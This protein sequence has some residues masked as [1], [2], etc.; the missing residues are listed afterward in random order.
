MVPEGI[1]RASC[2]AAAPGFRRPSCRRLPPR[3][4]EVVRGPL[5]RAPVAR[6]PAQAPP[7]PARRPGSSPA[8]AAC[9]ASASAR[10]RP[11]GQTPAR[12]RRPRPPRRRRRRRR[13]RPRRPSTARARRAFRAGASSQRPSPRRPFR[14]RP[15]RT[16]PPPEARSPRPRRSCRPRRPRA[17]P[18]CGSGAGARASW[19]APPRPCPHRVAASS[20]GAGLG[21][22]GRRPARPA[23]PGALLQLEPLA[24]LALHLRQL[25]GVLRLRLELDRGRLGVE[26]RR[27]GAG[28]AGAVDPDAVVLADVADRPTDHDPVAPVQAGDPVGGVVHVRLGDLDAKL[29]AVGHGQAVAV[30]VGARSLA[31]HVDLGERHPLDRLHR[32]ALAGLALKLDQLRPAGAGELRRDPCVHA[33]EEGVGARRTGQLPEPPLGLDR[34]RLLGEDAALAAAGRDRSG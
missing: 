24:D 18:S 23:R 16:H 5:R 29:V 9:A 26:E 27:V 17:R 19:P 8:S 11:P 28:A 1:L 21:L 15:R 12:Q 2:P 6:A 22:R 7:R 31:D 30:D 34:H 4:P 13:S 10:P 14:R 25:V 20:F 3:P 33:D 32:E